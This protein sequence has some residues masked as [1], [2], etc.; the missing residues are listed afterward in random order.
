[1]SRKPY[2]K[3]STLW[4]DPIGPGTPAWNEADLAVDLYREG[5]RQEAGAAMARMRR[6][7]K[8]SGQAGQIELW[9][10]WVSEQRAMR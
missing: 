8:T 2:V 9:V 7:L 10:K 5:K 6:H 1:M 3:Q 4:T